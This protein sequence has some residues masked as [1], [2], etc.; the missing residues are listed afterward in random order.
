[1]TRSKSE[2]KDRVTKNV[3]LIWDKYPYA[4]SAIAIVCLIVGTVFGA[5]WF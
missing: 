5:W 2:I 1:M 4:S 3:P